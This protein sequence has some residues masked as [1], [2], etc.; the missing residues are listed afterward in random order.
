MKEGLINSPAVG[1]RFA[2]DGLRLIWRPGLRRY[3]VVPFLIN[4]IVFGLLVWLGVD[5][6]EGV[7]DRWLPEDSWLG[8]FR[9]LLWPLFA[10][11]FLLIVF[12]TFTLLANLLAAP[13]NDMLSAKVEEMLTGQRP[14]DSAGSVFAAVGPAI[15][16][17]LQKI[18][19]FLP[20]ALPLLLL[21]VI[22]GI[23]TLAPLI[24]GVFSAW[25]IALEYTEYPFGN[26]GVLF[27]QQ[28][29]V[30][31]QRRFTALGFGGGVMLLMLI[32]GVNFLAMPAA[33]AG[34]TALWVARLKV[35]AETSR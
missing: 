25:S 27:R 13:F 16:S 9:W 22:P 3:V 21:F 30:V 11:A 31:R 32:P 4:L 29:Q 28:R 19:Y 15:R 5:Q 14:D 2:M 17:E 26:N 12:Y 8:Y 35:A 23:N 34:A 20:R 10:V 24:W 1:F 33:V 6:F 7:L 18:A